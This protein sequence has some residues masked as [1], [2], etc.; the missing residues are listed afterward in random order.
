[1]KKLIVGLG[2]D[3]EVN[4]GA[5]SEKNKKMSIY[6]S[7]DQSCISVLKLIWDGDVFVRIK[8][9]LFISVLSLYH[10]H[11]KNS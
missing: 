8:V 5:F 2:S 10:T 7:Q 3:P 4:F 1:M 11:F 6:C 9:R